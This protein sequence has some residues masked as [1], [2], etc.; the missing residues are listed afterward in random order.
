MAALTEVPSS[1]AR[2][3]ARQRSRTIDAIHAGQPERAATAQQ[4]AARRRYVRSHWPELD[5]EVVLEGF[6][7]RDD[8]LWSSFLARG[9]RSSRGVARVVH[10]DAPAETRA[11]GTAFLIGEWLAV[12]N[13]HVVGSPEA[14]A[15]AAIEFNFE[16]DEDGGERR[17]G[18]VRL[19]PDRLFLTNV[20]TGEMD[21]TVVAVAAT[22]SGS[23]PGKAYGHLPL[24]RER[25][26]AQNGDP[27]NLIH[28]PAGMRKRITVRESRLLGST[29]TT[30]HY[31]GDTLGGSSG[32]PV[33][34]DQWEVVGL[35]F[36]GKPKRRNRRRLTID[37]RLWDET[38]PR[39]LIAYEFNVGTRVSS[40]VDDMRDRA[41]GLRKPAR[42][43]LFKEIGAP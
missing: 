42:E 33:L 20:V 31:S 32:S 29:E 6:V 41:P 34:N 14:A 30:L 27:L 40:L 10:R 8:T 12:T 21:Y 24:I 1:V 5:E 23:P 37:G 38:M 25:G 18:V 11:R 16:Y 4:R 9:A 26:K 28:H 43:L 36:G 17:A 15:A 3:T 2:A 7:G 13:N 39:E 35:H 19:D 22:R